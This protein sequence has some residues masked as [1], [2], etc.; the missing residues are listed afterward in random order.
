ME[1]GIKSQGAI[2]SGEQSM[3]SDSEVHQYQRIDRLSA[4][5]LSLLDTIWHYGIDR[6]FNRTIEQL[7]M[8]LYQHPRFA[9]QCAKLAT[10]QT[11]FSIDIDRDL[12][13]GTIAQMMHSH[14]VDAWRLIL[15]QIAIE[16]Q[17][18]IN[19]Y[20]WAKK[21]RMGL[22]IERLQTTFTNKN[23]VLH[24]QRA[25]VRMLG[26]MVEDRKVQ[27]N[28]RIEHEYEMVMPRPYSMFGHWFKS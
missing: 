22:Y 18:G 15:L 1:D 20:L 5:A 26:R 17:R 14:I 3:L 12:Q 28:T 13:S 4:T 11:I 24:E 21:R 2:W 10:Y 9:E 16:V 6:K 23:H 19:T 25:I 8:Q 7:M 27:K